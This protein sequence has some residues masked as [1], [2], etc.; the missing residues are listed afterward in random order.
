VSADELALTSYPI[1]EPKTSVDEPALTSFSYPVD[2]SFSL[3]V[4]DDISADEL[5][6][7]TY[8]KPIASKK[9]PGTGSKKTVSKNLRYGTST[10]SRRRQSQK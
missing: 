2:V 1:E 3:P 5:G 4:E 10:S 7:T 9:R 8:M 6:H